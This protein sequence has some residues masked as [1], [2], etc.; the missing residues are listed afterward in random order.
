MLD[1]YLI[2]HGETEANRQG[3]VQ[4]HSDSPMTPAGIEETLRKAEKLKDIEFHGGYCSDLARAMMTLE[5]IARRLP[6]LPGA[7]I[8]RELREIDFGEYTGRRKDDIMDDIRRHKTDTSL[9]YPGGESGRDLIGRVRGFFNNLLLCHQNERI[10][11]VTHYGVIETAFRQ[12]T[13]HP[14]NAPVHVEPY[15]VFHLSFNSHDNASVNVL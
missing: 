15:D 4:G 13:A 2:R 14:Q 6:S 11:V 7:V 10:L 3:I 1:I 9:T 8:L 5:L 12:F